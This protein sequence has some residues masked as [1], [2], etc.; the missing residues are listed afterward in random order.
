MK[1]ISEYPLWAKY[2]I[3]GSFGLIIIACIVI[4]IL[5][6]LGVLSSDS[7]TTLAP[8]SVSTVTV[9]LGS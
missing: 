3:L 6:A 5:A 9:T 4:I 2:L 8:T 1:S 7:T